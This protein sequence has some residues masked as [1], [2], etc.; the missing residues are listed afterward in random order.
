[1]F[2]KSLNFEIKYL[3]NDSKKKLNFVE[4]SSVARGGCRPPIGMQSMQKSLFLV[5]LR[6]IF[7]RKAKIAPLPQLT[8]A[9]RI[10]LS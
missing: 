1:M 5:L 2:G 4:I 10:R 6:P 7:A 9:M 8:L 3:Q